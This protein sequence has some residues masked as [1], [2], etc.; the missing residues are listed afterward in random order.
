MEYELFKKQCNTNSF[1]VFKIGGC[2]INIIM[3]SRY[4]KFSKPQQ[5]YCVHHI[6]NDF[7]KTTDLPRLKLREGFS[8]HSLIT[9]THFQFVN[10]TYAKAII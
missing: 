4:Q 3:C 6:S 8:N 2:K 10:C 1:P 5:K 7:N 9:M